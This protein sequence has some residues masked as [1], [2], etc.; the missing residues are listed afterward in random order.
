M[1]L[2]LV[3]IEYLVY[4]FA[5]YN[6]KISN[7]IYY[8]DTGRRTYYFCKALENESGREYIF[9]WLKIRPCYL[10]PFPPIRLCFSLQIKLLITMTLNWTSP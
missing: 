8:I 9:P 7:E 2:K 4:E 10:Q 5:Y 3:R 1:V 6:I